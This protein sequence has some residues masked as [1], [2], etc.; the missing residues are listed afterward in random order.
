MP[1]EKQ[2]LQLLKLKVPQNLKEELKILSVLKGLTM[3]ETVRQLI[4]D[5]CQKYHSEIEE[6]RERKAQLKSEKK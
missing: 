6:I 4:T 2:E 1:I 3:S 5:T